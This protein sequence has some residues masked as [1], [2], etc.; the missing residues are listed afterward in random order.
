[1]GSDPS[2]AEPLRLDQ[3][4]VRDGLAETRSRAQALIRA[5][6]VRLG[7]APCKR[8]AQ[9]APEDLAID[10]APPRGEGDATRWV[11]RAALKLLHGLDRFGLSPAGAA[12][13]DLGASTG[14]F[15]EVLLARG[16][17]RVYAVDVG[18]DQ[19][20]SSLAGDPRVVS[21]EG[22]NAKALSR[23][24]IPEPIEF[25]TADL[26]FI[27]LA[28]AL[29]APLA[30]TAP[31]AAALLLVKPQFEV[32]PADVGKNGLVREAAARDAA[33][34]GV[35]AFLEA[36]GWRVLGADVSPILGGDGNEERLLAAR[37]E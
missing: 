36:A 31:G 9:P 26:A 20:H 29:P 10:L 14:G 12:A 19:L 3:R 21:L 2:C 13:L 4:L 23:A 25:V 7:G 37:R 17:A 28:K 22:V 24:A 11:S 8:P 15:T 16:A 34:A 35:S 6:R 5:G 30:L 33:V 1:M 32:G 27:S 18:R